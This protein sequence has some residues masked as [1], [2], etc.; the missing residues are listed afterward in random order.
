MNEYGE[1]I[2]LKIGE[3]L[4]LSEQHGGLQFRPLPKPLDQNGW[5]LEFFFDARSFGGQE[6]S[7]YAIVLIL[8]G[9]E[10]ALSS[11]IRVS[12]RNYHRL[13]PPISDFSR[14]S[15]KRRRLR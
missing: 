11:L 4:S 5:L 2:G 3:S 13:T 12:I 6:S 10:Y 14:S 1:T 7:R 8:H 15:P 9:S